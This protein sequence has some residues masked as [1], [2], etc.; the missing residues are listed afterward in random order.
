M[1]LVVAAV[2]LAAG[3]AFGGQSNNSSASQSRAGPYAPG[4]CPWLKASLP[5][6][7]RVGELLAAMTLQEK[8][9]EMQPVRV[10]GNAF[11]ST[12]PAQ[13]ALCIPAL[14]A[15]DGDAGVSHLLPGGT[16]FPD[17]ET[18]AAAWSRSLSRQY[19]QAIAAEMKAK[20]VAMALAPMVDIV[21]DPRW[22]RTFE[23]LGEDPYLSSALGAAEIGGIQSDGVMAVAKH[24][25]SYNQES[26]RGKKADDVLVSERALHEIYLPPFHSAVAAGSAS[27]MCALS[28][29]NG[30]YACDNQ[31]FLQATLDLRWHYGGFTRADNSAVDS[32]TAVAAGLDAADTVGEVFTSGGALASDVESGQVSMAEINDAVGRIL[33]QM[34]RFGLFNHPAA[35]HAN[36]VVTSVAHKALSEQLAEDGTVLLKDE[37]RILPLGP[38]SSGTNSIAVIGADANSAPISAGG[39]SSYVIPVGGVVSPYK[40]IVAA[41]PAGTAVRYAEGVPAGSAQASAAEQ[42]SLLE[43]AV[44]TA[45]SAKVAVVFAANYQSE[46]F[47][48]SNIT[49]QNN[50]DR[51]IEAVAAANPNTVVILNTGSAVT[52]PWLPR[53][54]AVVEAWYPGQEDGNA[55]ASVLFGK[56][57]PGGHLTMTFPQS[58]SQVPASSPAE[59]PG[60]AGAVHY[61]EG[62]DVGYRWYDSH[63]LTPL[64]PFGYGLSYTTFKF[65][66]L[67]ITAAPSL[68]AGSPTTTGEP[69][70][71]NAVSTPAPS[72]CGCNGQSNALVEVSATVTNTGSVTGSDVAQLYLGDP[73]VAGEPPRQLKGFKR[74]TLRPGHSAELH[75]VLDGHDLSYW[76]DAANGWVLPDGTYDVHVGDSS[77]LANLPLGGSFRAVKT[78]GALTASASASSGS[79]AVSPGSPVTISATFRNGGDFTLSHA[80]SSLELPRGWTAK[81]TSGPASTTLTGNQSLS[82]SWSVTPPL[83]AEGD[84]ASV[85]A[86]LDYVPV[87]ASSRRTTEAAVRLTVAPLVSMTSAGAPTPIKQGTSVQLPVRLVSNVG[88]GVTLDYASSATGGIALSNGS[89]SLQVGTSASTAELTVTATTGA[90]PGIGVLEVQPSVEEGGHTYALKVFP[91]TVWVPYPALASAFNNTGVSSDEKDGAA[92][93][94]GLGASYSQQ[95]LNRA[96]LRPGAHVGYAGTSFA[97]PS[98]PSGRPDNV[99]LEGQFIAL[100]GS[101][102]RLGFLGAGT[103]GNRAAVCTILYADGARQSFTLQLSNWQGPP[104]PQDKVYAKLSGFDLRGGGSGSSGDPEPVPT[105]STVSVF[106]ASVPLKAGKPLFGVFLGVN[107]WMHIFSLGIGS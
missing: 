78:L 107:K 92:N 56:V 55:I 105:T 12:I 34:F 68:S 58:L 29:P 52:M 100:S 70:I 63:D 81:T 53:V 74:V 40:A 103:G 42:Q 13:P 7:T 20:G 2:G 43:A 3:F 91:I 102:A 88:S 5:V 47:D 76:S 60:V 85:I 86:R 37:G 35:S 77:A 51:L 28:S 59:W 65:S 25:F 33:T 62:I 99:S 6:Q 4:S 36:S 94:D 101:G 46:G 39:G 82:E 22:G 1:A 26:N 89:G 17:P 50:Q 87:G 9:A 10:P 27:V 90:R 54:K 95:A 72:S 104:V 80:K 67:H 96:G 48:L 14:P 31:P 18:V 83:A 23:T 98:A 106:Y 45:A 75:F 19:G 15:E 97:W 61:S 49:L 69:A 30:T 38:A 41:S 73:G 24:F 57:D 32:A 21:R 8:I 11:E 84:S 66:N 71:V 93:L 44:K 64:F 79:S 16:Q